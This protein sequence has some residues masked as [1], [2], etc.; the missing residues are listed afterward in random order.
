LTTLLLAILAACSR[1]EE[2]TMVPEEPAE[3]PTE[4]PAATAT[5]E[6]EVVAAPTE[7]PVISQPIYRWGEVADRVWILV[8]Y[9]DA[10][11]PTVVEEGA[12]VSAIF[13]SVE[14]TVNG[15]GGCNNYFA[16]YESGD[17]GSLTISGPIGAT[18]M[19]CETGAEQEAAYFAALEQVTGWGLTEEGR[20]ELTYDSGQPYEEKLVYAP[21]ETPLI[22]T[23]WKLL[24]Y[25]DPEE[26]IDVLPGTAITAV[27]SP[28]TDES[29]A[30]GGN[31]TCN[32]Y[33]GG[34]TLDG[35]QISFG[36]IAGT[37]MMCPIGADQEAA[38]LAALNTAQTYAIV[39]PNL[40]I[41]YEDGVLNFT[42]L[43]LPL[44]NVFWQALMVAGEPVPEEVEIT[45]LFTPGEEADMGVLGGSAG[46]NSYNADY[47]SSSD[48][49]TNPPTHSLA[50]EGPMAVTL[51]ICPDEALADLEQSY[52]AALEAAE[53]Y[54]I[55]GDQLVMHTA[56]GDIHYTADRQPLLGTLWVLTSVGTLEDPQPPL[57]D[58]NFTAQ[59]NRL[60]SLP[61]GTVV[62]ETGCNDYN[63]TFTANLTEIK[64][65][66][67]ATTRKTCGD[68]QAEAEQQFFLTLNNATEYRILGN[69]LQI[70][71]DDGRQALTFEGTPPPVEEVVD[72]TP[73][74][75]TFWYLLSIGDN[76]LL[77]QTQ[78]TAG[79]TVDEA[80]T[81]GAIRGS[82][83]CNSYNAA[84]GEN[85]AVGPI[86]TT[87][88]AC[89]TDVMDQEGG[90]LDWLGK[91]YG[92][93][94][95]G[96]QLLISTANGVLTFNSRPVQDQSRELQDVTW[97]LVS[98]GTLRAV[99][100]SDA[101]T[102]FAGDGRTVSGNSGC[103]EFSGSYQAEPGNKLTISGFASTLAACPTEDL[104]SQEEALLI[105]LQSATAYTIRGNALQIQTVD[106]ST[107]NY[108][109]VPPAGAVGPTAAISGESQADVGQALVFD[110]S[111]STAGSTPVTRYDWDMGD[112]TILSG[113]AVQYAYQDA[114]SFTIRLTVS[115]RSGLTSSATQGI[116][117]QPVAEAQPPTA[118]I[119]GPGMAFAGA[120]VAFSAANA[121]PGSSDIS[122]YIWDDGA[123]NNSG[124]VPD[125]SFSTIYGLPGTYYAS[126]TVVDANGLS[127]SASIA[128][129]VNANL[130]GTDWILEDTV[131]GTSISLT[132]ANGILEGF[133]GCNDYT[134]AYTATL[135]TVV[136]DDLEVGLIASTQAA[137]AVDIMDQEQGYFAALAMVTR[138]TISGDTLTLTL[139]DDTEL[140]FRAALV[141]PL[142][143]P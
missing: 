71:Y 77:P 36:T 127:D 37:L 140:V 132:F 6:P 85:F 74:A 141:V 30:I 90:Y 110:G 23:T 24:S 18:M 31:A 118:A 109:S 9:G 50:I 126:V 48:T 20:L 59:F 42:S 129:Q 79:F 122:S 97:Y 119:E 66:L 83:G 142:N 88:R 33:T 62:G 57:A 137:C 8:G 28:E 95:A 16:G 78:I 99:P 61:S 103:N 53:D 121:V 100:G 1:E 70:L 32:A 94:R 22:G 72:L 15:S 87:R 143:R 55:L 44:E 34:Y 115:D 136:E 39:G 13:S 38:Y 134:A 4:A 105:F 133:A 67:P 41:S 10:L 5:T 131:E 45:A 26:P 14:P 124:S 11:N 138:Y 107:I 52:L 130:E 56:D 35:E 113:A 82:A 139:E 60:P 40:E 80:G 64:V 21:G 91:A 58:S 25:G 125:D 96:D 54:E 19:A 92:Y 102:I 123:G 98:A 114:G 46:C 117:V 49:S 108:T 27:F 86:A 111:G 128:I 84:I 43:N 101:T 135:S 106:G 12:L 65:N 68:A 81:T 120:S 7:A 93:T 116:Q 29:G 73:L 69:V 76:A 3:Q 112:G 75:N 17:E 63:A 104:T 2:P 47:E 51:S 89:E